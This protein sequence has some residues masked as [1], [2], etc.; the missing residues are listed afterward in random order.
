M[1]SAILQAVGLGIAI[2]MIAGAAGLDGSARGGITLLAA[3]IGLAAGVIAASA[4][5]DSVIVG[6]I[7]G[8]L[9]ACLGC[10]VVSDV[11][12][13]ARRRGGAG[14]GALGFIITVTAIAIAGISILVPPLALVPLIGLLW[15]GFARRRRAQRKYEGLRVLR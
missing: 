6:A 5:D 10:I 15:L 9:G 3:I 2:G 1:L 8:F 7:F 4:D 12:A 11:V 13:G 14:T